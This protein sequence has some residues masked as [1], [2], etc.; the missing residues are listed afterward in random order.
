MTVSMMRLSK[1]QQP[2]QQELTH[3]KL[4]DLYFH[5]CKTDGHGARRAWIYER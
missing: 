2:K 3:S 4:Q 1:Q 5:P